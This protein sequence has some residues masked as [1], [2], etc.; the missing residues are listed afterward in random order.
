MI[1]DGLVSDHPSHMLFSSSLRLVRQS[2]VLAWLII[3]TV[4]LSS[5]YIIWTEVTR[6]RYEG[7]DYM[8]LTPHHLF[9]I[10]SLLPSVRATGPVQSVR[11]RYGSYGRNT[12]PVSHVQKGYEGDDVTHVLFGTLLSCLSSSLIVAPK[13]RRSSSLSVSHYSFLSLPITYPS[14]EA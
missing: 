14:I 12:G 8:T 13:V 9:L 11:K 10:H 5:L 3:L 1:R 7:W 2:S 4:S 6:W